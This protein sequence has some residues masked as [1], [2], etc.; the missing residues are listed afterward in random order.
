[1]YNAEGVQFGLFGIDAGVITVD[2]GQDLLDWDVFG[3]KPGGV[4]TGPTCGL[5]WPNL[6]HADPSRNSEIVEAWVK[7]LKPY[8]EKPETLLARNSSSFRNQ[9]VHHVCTKVRI[10]EDE[11]EIDFMETNKLNDQLSN[12]QLTVKIE[13]ERKL[14]FTSDDLK[15]SDSKTSQEKN[16]Y[17]YTLEIDR[18]KDLEKS[19]VKFEA[20]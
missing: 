20:S 4:L 14:T 18:I 7:L 6:L 15:I 16:K 13:S 3:G 5:H 1:M 12:N 9:L 2:R 17:L 10:R 8:N 19:M 11:I